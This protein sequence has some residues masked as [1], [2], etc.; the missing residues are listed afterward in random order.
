VSKHILIVDDSE[1]VRAATQHFLESDADFQVCGQAV[2][3]LDALEKAHSLSPDL[4][5][6]DLA[7]PR[8]DGLHAARALRDR[9]VLAPII[10]FTM[11]ADAVPIQDAL[12]AGVSAVVSKM[13]LPEL[14]QQ[15]KNLLVS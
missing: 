5:I 15:I 6:L 8:L 1:V 12:A 4:I 7:M 10:L 2:D 3:G 9:K 11:H 13:N 14:R